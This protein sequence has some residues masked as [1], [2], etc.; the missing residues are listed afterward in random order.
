M[1]P[2]FASS[3]TLRSPLPM[4]MT[5][6][7]SCRTRRRTLQK[8]VRLFFFATRTR[9][10]PPPPPSLH[11]SPPPLS[12]VAPT[13]FLAVP[14]YYKDIFVGVIGC[15]LEPPPTGAVGKRLYVMVLAVLAPYRDRGLGA[16]LLQQVLDAVEGGRVKGA[17]DIAEVYCHVWEDN[18]AAVRFYE[19]HGFVADAAR[20]ENYYK[21]IDNPHAIVLRKAVARGGGA[22]GGGAQ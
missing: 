12:L 19:R 4:G 22:G 10:P 8:W 16:L 15:R 6:T 2:L 13:P 20:I 11:T 9:R 18:K 5:F 17:E 7:S 21:R 1:L 14:V 3:S